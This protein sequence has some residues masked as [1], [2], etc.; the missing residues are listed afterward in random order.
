MDAIL[1]DPEKLAAIVTAL[2]ALAAPLVTALLRKVWPAFDFGPA[3]RKLVVALLVAGIG[4]FLATP[5]D[6]QTK[7]VAAVVAA[8]LAQGVYG[9]VRAARTPD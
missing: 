9:T 2:V 4:A 8:I 6:W 1:Q 3:R 5:G 7:L